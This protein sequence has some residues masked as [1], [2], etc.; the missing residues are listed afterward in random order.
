MLR[1]AE[2][3]SIIGAKPHDRLAPCNGRRSLACRPAIGILRQPQFAMLQVVRAAALSEAYP[4]TTRSSGRELV[5]VLALC[6]ETGSEK[7]S[8]FLLQSMHLLTLIMV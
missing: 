4:D 8:E 5:K 2:V 3:L 1:L 7:S 6:E